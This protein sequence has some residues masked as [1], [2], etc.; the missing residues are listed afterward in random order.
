VTW[1]GIAAS[2]DGSVLYGLETVAQEGAIDVI[3]PHTGQMRKLV[4]PQFSDILGIA[5]VE[6]NSP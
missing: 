2:L 1:R 3:D 5:G 4:K 6:P